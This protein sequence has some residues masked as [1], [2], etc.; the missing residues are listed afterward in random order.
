MQ[1]R[2]SGLQV[3]DDERRVV[4]VITEYDALFLLIESHEP[5]WPVIPVEMLMSTDV[6]TVDEAMGLDEL[7]EH[8]R[9][10]KVRRL[11][12]LR[13]GRLVGIVSRREVIRAICNWRG[14]LAK[15]PM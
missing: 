7:T 15:L 2:I 8:F 12:V 3:V 11:P 4:G 13:D 10:K 5:Y 9:E 6:E 1:H 14:E